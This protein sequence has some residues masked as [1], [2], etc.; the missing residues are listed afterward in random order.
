MGCGA[1]QIEIVTVGVLFSLFAIFI[2]SK[3]FENKY[4]KFAD[5]L[6]L[7]VISDKRLSEKEIDEQMEQLKKYSSKIEL[8]S[9]S[10]SGN[11][12]TINYDIQLNEFSDLNKLIDNMQKEKT[13]VIVARNNLT[14]L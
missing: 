3:F 7:A 14:A 12:T 5:T 2:Y 6:N 9:F 11:N 13:K 1:G 8:V 4:L 10:K